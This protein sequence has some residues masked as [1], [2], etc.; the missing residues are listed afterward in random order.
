MA[1]WRR[2]PQ[3]GGPKFF[4]QLVSSKSYNIHTRYTPGDPPV[5]KNNCQRI[6]ANLRR[7]L[8]VSGGPDPPFLPWRRH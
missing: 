6:C 7:G 3:K 1:Q 5:Y 2:Q 8:N 4:S